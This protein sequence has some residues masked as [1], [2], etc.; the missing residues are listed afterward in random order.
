MEKVK[1][2]VPTVEAN[3]H[4][5]YIRI[6]PRKVT[7]VLDLIRNKPIKLAMAILKNTPKSASEYLIKLLKSASANAENNCHMD[8]ERLYVSKCFVT[9]GPILKRIR[10]KDHGRSHRI[11]KRSSHVTITLKELSE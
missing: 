4:V 10:P 2:N 11:E 7:V 8:V 3:A 9:P 5:K 1:E 6:S